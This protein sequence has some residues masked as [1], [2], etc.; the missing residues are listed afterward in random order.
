MLCNV[1]LNVLLL[2]F[3]HNGYLHEGLVRDI[4]L[5]TL[6]QPVRYGPTLRPVCLPH[7][8]MGDYA[9]A[10]AIVAGHGVA[11]YK[12]SGKNQKPSAGQ[13]KLYGH[14]QFSRMARSSF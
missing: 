9:W 3:R 10:T 8:Q 13:K 1:S 4:A 6:S 2:S 7:P 14:I 12:G 11:G 5:L